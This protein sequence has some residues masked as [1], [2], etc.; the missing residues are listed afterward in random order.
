MQQQYLLDIINNK[1]LHIKV[2]GAVPKN[3]T[4][5]ATHSTK[6]FI[7]G[8][9]AMF[10]ASNILDCGHYEHNDID[11]YIA[12]V[13]DSI[14]GDKY[15]NILLEDRK[16]SITTAAFIIHMY[17]LECC[18]FFIY[19][20]Y[21]FAAE[22]AI[23]ALTNKAFSVN[24]RFMGCPDT[25]ERV[26]KYQG[27]GFNITTEEPEKF[28]DIT[29]YEA[30]I[31][32]PR[33]TILFPRNI[34][35]I[36]EEL[37]DI[38]DGKAIVRDMGRG[39][40]KIKEHASCLADSYRKDLYSIPLISHP[41]KILKYY[42]YFIKDISKVEWKRIDNLPS[43]D[44]EYVLCDV[45]VD[46]DLIMVEFGTRIYRIVYVINKHTKKGTYKTYVG[47]YA[48]SGSLVYWHHCLAR[49]GISFDNNGVYLA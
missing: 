24:S 7:G 18:K 41:S 14:Q 44:K 3:N 46:N 21:V 31:D 20:G 34:N 23:E 8:S 19:G 11:V 49:L 6:C 1:N 12:D 13:S 39:L 9:Y 17:D 28:Y 47:R 32:T 48:D 26:K 16:I 30:H 42:D 25:I 5:H 40:D 27:R 10:V 33:N 36:L 37:F 35:K 2:I 45:V 4:N 22:G 29:Y 43:I 38:K 15:Q